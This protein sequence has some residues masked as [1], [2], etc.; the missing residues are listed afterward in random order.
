MCR[1]AT[2]MSLSAWAYAAAGY[3]RNRSRAPET[4][5]WRCFLG[6]FHNDAVPWPQYDKQGRPGRKECQ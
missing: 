6:L 1:V 4:Q 3:A 5:L 2:A